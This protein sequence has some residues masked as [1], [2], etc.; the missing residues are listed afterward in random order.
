MNISCISIPNNLDRKKSLKIPF[1]TFVA[2]CYELIVSLSYI[3]ICIATVRYLY[4]RQTHD[5]EHEH[6]CICVIWIINKMK[7]KTIWFVISAHTNYLS[8]SILQTVRLK[9]KWELL[10]FH[11][12][13]KLVDMLKSGGR[14]ENCGN[15]SWRTEKNAPNIWLSHSK[16]TNR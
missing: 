7:A 1:H 12:R 5:H 2:K 16:H 3:F 14:R 11:L 15:Q 4:L 9:I 10:S 8:P 13:V 6:S